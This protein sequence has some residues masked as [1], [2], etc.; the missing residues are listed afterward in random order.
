MCL[1]WALCCTRLHTGKHLSLA[2]H[3]CVRGDVFVLYFLNIPIIRSYLSIH[4]SAFG[5][6]Y[7]GFL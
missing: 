1:R 3:S 7:R 2:H 4:V 5:S 6:W